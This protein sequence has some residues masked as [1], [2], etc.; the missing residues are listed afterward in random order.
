[1]E[2]VISLN[3][4]KLTRY[5]ESGSRFQH[6]VYLGQ[7]EKDISQRLQQLGAEE[8]KVFEYDDTYKDRFLRAYIDLI[9]K[10][11]QRYNSIYWWA[12]HTAAKNPYETVASFDNLFIHY[13]I[14]RKIEELKD[15]TLLIINPPPV[16]YSSIAKYC[17]RRSVK[18]RVLAKPF[19][20]T[21][22]QL[23]ELLG[24]S[25]YVTYVLQIWRRIYISKRH[26]KKRL[27]DEVNQKESYCVLRT[28]FYERAI[29][30]H[31]E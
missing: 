12:T 5:L 21:I 20:T 2:V 15:G 6:Y 3:D 13:H 11:G 7:R 29:N 9:G 19:Q 30:D 18:L 4:N 8:L 16:L 14:V 31:G 1:M 17:A 23:K 26:L 27:L 25:K 28:W 22:H 24:Y 10:L